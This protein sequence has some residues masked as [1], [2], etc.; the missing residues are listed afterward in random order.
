MRNNQSIKVLIFLAFGLS[1]AS[2]IKDDFVDDFMEEQ[3]RITTLLDSIEINSSFQLEASYFNN[4]GQVE[5]VDFEWTSSNPEIISVDNTGLATALS[6]GSSNITV[7][8]NSDGLVL[9]DEKELAVGNS[10]V[11]TEQ[12]LTGFIEPSSFYVLEGDFTF[13]ETADGVHIEFADNYKASTA[14]PGLYVYLTNNRNSIANAFEIGE[15]DVFSGEHEYNVEGVGFQEYSFLLYFCKP[16]NVKVG[17]GE[18]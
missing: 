11:N 1:F 7:S 2:C 9:S 14:L 5:E 15:V 3:I 4:V 6:E 16:F 18:L 12:S 17:D 13:T 10:T 8:Y